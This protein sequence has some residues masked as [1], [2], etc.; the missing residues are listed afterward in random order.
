ME[1]PWLYYTP[2]CS[3]K[4]TWDKP[5]LLIM[6]TVDWMI[7]WKKRQQTIQI[8]VFKK[9]EKFNPYLHQRVCAGAHECVHYTIKGVVVRISS[10]MTHSLTCGNEPN[11]V[12]GGNNST[13]WSFSLLFSLPVEWQSST[14]STTLHS[15][16]GLHCQGSQVMLWLP[17]HLHRSV[18]LVFVNQASPTYI[19]IQILPK[20]QL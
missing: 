18:Q 5:V 16:A 15:C 20:K 6:F 17:I 7:Y 8:C 14:P 1:S 12:W 2:K 3:R 19:C 4:T 9:C 10:H 13:C 11:N